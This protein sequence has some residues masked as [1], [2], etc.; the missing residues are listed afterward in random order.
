MRASIITTAFIAVEGAHAWGSLG[1]TTI[2]YIAE[3]LIDKKGEAWA[4]DILNA[5]GNSSAGYLAGVATWADSYRST[6]EGKFSAPYHFID[7]EDDPPT[8]CDVDYERDCGSAG[9]VVSAIANYTQRVQQTQALS[10]QQVNYAL[11]FLIHFIGDITQPLHDEA[12][13]LGGN[14][15]PVKFNNK[16]TN[17]HA[18]WDTSIPEKFVGGYSLADAK[19]WAANLT[20]EIQK[21]KYK[22]QAKSWFTKDSTIS[23]PVASAMI[24]ARDGNAY[25]CSE[26]IPDG[27]P[28]VQGMELSG[29]YYA[30][31]IDTV[32]MQIAKGG[33]RLANWLDQLAAASKKVH[34][35][36][37]VRAA[38][39][40]FDIDALLPA[41]RELSRAKLARQAVGWDCGHK[42]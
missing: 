8:T 26:V 9:C 39:P 20:M 32:E 6:A 37:F 17:L 7:A 31:T 15:I 18:T 40:E 2:G 27:V 24:W 10:A 13:A 29:A 11:R 35:K 34:S 19:E 41:P 33:Y 42:H 36:K 22:K 3:N 38:T 16:T 5:T 21:G 14:T 28:A 25:V 12:L 23:D 30:D 1:H 4:R